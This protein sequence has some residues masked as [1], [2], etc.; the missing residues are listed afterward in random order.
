ML[1]AVIEHRYD[2]LDKYRESLLLAHKEEVAAMRN[3]TVHDMRIVRNLK[4][5]LIRNERTV[6]GFQHDEIEKGL[7]LSPRLHTIISMRRELIAVWARS[8]A[9]QDELVARLQDWVSRAEA[10]GIAPLE[11]FSRRLRSY[12]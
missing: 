1:R 7:A 10:S 8:M 6:S 3:A 4:R 11:E 2:I 5:W 9:S 12:A